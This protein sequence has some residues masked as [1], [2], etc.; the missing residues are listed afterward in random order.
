M[1]EKY[2]S[3][4]PYAYCANN[5]VNYIDPDG[6]NPIVIG[7][8]VLPD[9]EFALISAGVVTTGFILYKTKEGSIS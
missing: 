5:P 9:A 8:V 2:Y 6:K 7:E 1:A 3:V 4:S